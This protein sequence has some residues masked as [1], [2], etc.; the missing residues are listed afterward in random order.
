MTDLHGHLG[1]ENPQTRAQYTVD[2]HLYLHAL[3]IHRH[4]PLSDN[5]INVW[6]KMYGLDAILFNKKKKKKK[7]EN[8]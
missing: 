2:I 3:Y 1:L 6:G 8:T 5:A 4:T 7:K